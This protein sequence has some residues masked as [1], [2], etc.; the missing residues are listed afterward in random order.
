MVKPF[1]AQIERFVRS[2]E[3]ISL[4]LQVIAVSAKQIARNTAVSAGEMER[5]EHPLRHPG[6]R[7]A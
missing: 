3:A 2:V 4:N 5:R 1:S 6:D 7:E